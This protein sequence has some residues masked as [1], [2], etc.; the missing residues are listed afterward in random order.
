MTRVFRRV[1]F[2]CGAVAAC[3]FSAWA[4]SSP[5]VGDTTF[6]IGNSTVFG[7]AATVN[8]GAVQGFQ[9][10][11]RFDLTSL[12][13]GTT[14]AGVSSAQLRLFVNRIGSAGAINVYA[15]SG[16]WTEPAVNGT[17]NPVP[18]P[19]VAGPISISVAGSFISIPVTNQVK[20]WIT[21]PSTNNGF[22]LQA[23]PSSTAVFF[24][25]KESTN[26]SHPAVLEIDF[27]GQTGSAGAIGATGATGAA[28]AAGATG[29]QGPQ[30]D[31]GLTGAAGPAGATGAAGPTGV[32]GSAGTAGA[33][34]PTGPPGFT[35]ATG[36]AG[37]QGIAGVTGSTGN[38][39]PAGA[40][41][42]AGPR[43][44]TGLAGATGATGA[45]GPTGPPGLINN[46]FSISPVEP[47]GALPNVTQTV[48]LV[49]NTSASVISVTL[50]AATTTGEDIAV[51]LNDFS[52]G[53]QSANV[54]PAAGDS[55]IG[56]ATATICA[57]GCTLTSFQINFFAH[58]V[59]DGNHHWYCVINN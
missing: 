24:D 55:I 49:N 38:N 20:S 46:S 27:I 6:I 30:G 35:G 56:F 37:T 8:V 57:S 10:L 5:L 53:G 25:S 50:P 11:L 44:P 54:S 41:G 58:F 19:L 9:G 32:A 18:G 4:Q 36:S 26:T 15:A 52:N 34:G 39:G 33:K 48:I 1:L 12:P 43:G 21:S 31:P 22:L 2:I 51:L 29:P 3:R 13:P 7:T 47:A 14:A 16:A 23:S 59:S 45:Q 28:G 17:N 40:T 42:P